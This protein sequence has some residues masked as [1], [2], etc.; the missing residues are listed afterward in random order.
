MCDTK[1][2]NT[3][4]NNTYRKTTD[5]QWDQTRTQKVGPTGYRPQYGES[6]CSAHMWSILAGSDSGFASFSRS[7]TISESWPLLSFQF[8]FETRHTSSRKRRKRP[9][10]ASGPMVLLDTFTNGPEDSPWD[11]WV[12]TKP[13][14]TADTRNGARAEVG[15]TSRELGARWLGVFGPG[16]FCLGWGGGGIWCSCF[17]FFA[18]GAGVAGWCSLLQGGF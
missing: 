4:Q 16:L 18:G 10:D 2:Y 14:P 15:A 5:T 9:G 6:I 7:L 13:K 8:S 3:K 11:S 12:R 1:E 17:F